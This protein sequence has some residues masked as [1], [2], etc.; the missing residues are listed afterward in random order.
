M[1]FMTEKGY[2]R[3]L[4]NQIIQMDTGEISVK[5]GGIENPGER[6]FIL[7]E[8]HPDTSQILTES[9]D[10]GKPEIYIGCAK[11]NRQNLK[12]FYPK[13]TKDE[14]TY[15]AKQFNA[16][17]MNATY[18]RIYPPE[19]FIEWRE[20]VPEDFRFFPKINRYI[21]HLKWLNGIESRTEE[22][23]AGVIHLEEKL[24]TIFLQL[25]NRFAPKFMDR[26]IRFVERWPKN[27]PLAIELRHTDWYNNPDVARELYQLLEENDVSNV[28][29]DTAGRRDLL[30]MRLTN[31]EVFV[32]YVGANH[33]SDYSRLHE[34]VKRLKSWTEQGINKIAF[35]IH[36]NEEI[37]SPALARYFIDKL[38]RKVDSSVS[39]R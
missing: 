16:V 39:I 18:H 7:P 35:F 21:S 32:R 34:W 10:P 20:K 30:H 37:E 12:N 8:D 5:F 25:S 9:G 29:V 36:Q 17:E 13:G 28:I 19:Q 27:I 6:N 3:F 26:V 23:L 15:Y 4:C 14:L 2:I 11:W 22:F 33:P 38:T 1:I 24:G 31:S